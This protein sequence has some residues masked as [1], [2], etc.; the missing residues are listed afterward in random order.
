MLPRF[1]CHCD[2]SESPVVLYH[3]KFCFSISSKCFFFLFCM[4]YLSSAHHTAAPWECKAENFR[5][6][7]WERGYWK[8]W[9]LLILQVLNAL[10]VSSFELYK[11]K[12]NLEEGNFLNCKQTY[13]I[14]MAG[15]DC[16][17]LSSWILLEGVYNVVIYKKYIFALCP[18][19]LAH[20]FQNSWN[21]LSAESDKS[22][23]FYVNKVT[24]GK[25]L[26]M[27]AGCSWSK[28]CN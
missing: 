11:W 24:F 22:D 1:I 8:W 2:F 10:S 21:F 25:Y 26:R 27:G 23:F 14:K 13:S 28:L 12:R 9:S 3:L 6:H 4:N 20:S 19:Y 5:K 18:Q 15:S 16:E 17:G 7:A